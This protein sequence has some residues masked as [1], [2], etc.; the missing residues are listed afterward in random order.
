MSLSAGRVRWTA[1]AK[2]V[3]D[4]MESWGTG[5]PTGAFREVIQVCA[6]LVG[7]LVAAAEEWP[8]YY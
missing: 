6:G 7:R 4:G 8:G 3:T 1:C 5:G 2:E